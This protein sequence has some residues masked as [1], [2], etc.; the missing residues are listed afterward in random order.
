MNSVRS[1]SVSD[2]FEGKK[3][4]KMLPISAEEADKIPTSAQNYIKVR[5]RLISNL[6]FFFL[7][8]FYRN[9]KWKINN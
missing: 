2:G 1:L 8:F 9:W 6:S 5:L 3:M 4:L 7:F